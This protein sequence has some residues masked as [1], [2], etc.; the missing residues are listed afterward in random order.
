MGQS[1]LIEA[2]IDGGAQLN[3]I[4]AKLTKEQDLKVT[5]LPNL[6]AEAAN[7]SKMTLYG[8]TTAGVTITD[9]R[10]KQ[11]LQQISFV[12]ADLK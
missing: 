1:V 3:L 4:D 7:G 8:T 2:L 10:G 5:P 11:R 6:L 9:L 12:V